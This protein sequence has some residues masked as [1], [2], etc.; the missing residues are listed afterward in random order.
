MKSKHH[1]HSP[2]EAQW[3]SLSDLMTGMM[4]IFML[5]A[6]AYMVKVE[7][8]AAKAHKIAIL[9]EQTRDDLYN[10]L[11]NEFKDD[12]PKWGAELDKNLI[13]RF[14]EPDVL[15]DTGKDV[16]KPKFEEILGNF[17]PRYVR[18]ITSDKYKNSIQEIRI[19]GHT[20]SVWNSTT[21]PDDA[22]YLN[23]ELSQSRTR[24]VLKYVLRLADV[25]VARDWLRKYTT[26]N[27]LSSSKPILND[28]GTENPDKS[29]RVEFRIR[30]DADTRMA[31][32][33]ESSK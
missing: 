10:D 25:D 26:A 18:I 30:T 6:I 24:S 19:E 16:L 31:N 15:F 9:Y 23:M 29:Q 11:N 2:S 3:I 20:S 7:A 33:I 21:S 5:I 28:D 1:L 14:K 4:M 8:D 17:F 13:I 12:L 32:I 22:Y 27:G